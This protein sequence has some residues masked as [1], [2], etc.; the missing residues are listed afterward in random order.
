MLYSKNINIF[1]IN[2]YNFF[3]YMKN[4]SKTLG[5][6]LAQRREHMCIEEYNY[7]ILFS[8]IYNLY[9][10]IYIT[11]YE[12][13]TG[14]FRNKLFLDFI[15]RSLLIPSLSW[16]LC[17]KKIHQKFCDSFAFSVAFHINYLLE[18][19]IYNFLLLIEIDLIIELAN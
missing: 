19:K 5:M 15:F 17:Q 18:L 14:K 1:H 13:L 7:A 2:S 16:I 6:G 12:C 10:Y 4:K 11:V 3:L 9:M 8:Y